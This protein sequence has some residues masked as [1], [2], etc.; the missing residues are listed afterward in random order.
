MRAWRFDEADSLLDDA[1]RILDQRKAI[2]TAAA[3]SGLAVPD[4][5]RSAYESPDGFASATLEAAAELDVIARYDAAVAARL[6]AS[7]VVQEI[8]L[9]GTAP[10]A[11]L[12][13]AR[14]S[15]AA[16]DLTKAAAA[17]RSAD[18]A[19]SSA[20]DVGRGRLVGI[21]AL[22]LVILIAFALVAIWF[23]GRRG[24]PAG[25]VGPQTYATLA[26]TPDPVEG[27]DVEAQGARG[28]GPD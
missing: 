2:A 19:W 15:F 4:T 23:R 24:R 20:V 18:A 10:D 17:A 8:G 6:A 27:A 11:D 21:G 9:L 7:D 14:T 22:F 5:L 1:V 28:A 26:A 16:G 13:L 3:A 25:V 12:E